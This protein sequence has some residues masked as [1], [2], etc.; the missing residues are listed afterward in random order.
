M[1]NSILDA[2][3]TKKFVRL[4]SWSADERMGEYSLKNL[5]RTFADPSTNRQIKR[6]HIA[7]KNIEERMH[8]VMENIQIPEPSEDQIKKY[9]QMDWGEHLDRKSV[10]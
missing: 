4:G 5:E 7:K 6:E 9:L 10:V 2:N 8:Q 1:L 3:I